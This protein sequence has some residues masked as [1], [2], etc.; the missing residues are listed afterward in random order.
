M[1]FKKIVNGTIIDAVDYN[2]K[3]LVG[4]LPIVKRNQIIKVLLE[5]C[6]W[7]IIY[8]KNKRIKIT[9]EIDDFDE[10]KKKIDS[11]LHNL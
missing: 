6:I 9:I 7:E 8:M 2:P 3:E 5:D 11:S 4:D 10:I 1:K